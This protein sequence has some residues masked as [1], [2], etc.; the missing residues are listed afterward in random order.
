M[1]RHPNNHVNNRASNAEVYNLPQGAKPVFLSEGVVREIS[2][3]M[4][5]LPQH[6][7]ALFVLRQAN[8]HEVYIAVIAYGDKFVKGQS[9]DRRIRT[10][11]VNA[12]K[13]AKELSDKVDPIPSDPE[14][15]YGHGV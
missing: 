7:D 13:I 8:G 5:Y 9:P 12:F 3:S 2:M 10:G 1:Y 6:N 4:G 14:L 11:A 15:G